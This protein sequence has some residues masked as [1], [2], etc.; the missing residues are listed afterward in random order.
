MFCLMINVTFQKNGINFTVLQLQKKQPPVNV[1]SSVTGSNVVSCF[2]V[3]EKVK[4]GVRELQ[5]V[6]LRALGAFSFLWGG[7]YELF[8]KYTCGGILIPAVRAVGLNRP[9]SSRVVLYT[10]YDITLTEHWNR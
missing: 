6:V 2:W 1:Y 7:N 10:V 3:K 9:R 8:G 4:V 5:R